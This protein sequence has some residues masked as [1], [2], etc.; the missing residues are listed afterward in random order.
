MNRRAPF[1][2]KEKELIFDKMS[3][4]RSKGLDLDAVANDIAE[5]LNASK[6]TIRNTYHKIKRDKKAEENSNQKQMSFAEEV[7]ERDIIE[8]QNEKAN[9]KPKTDYEP[10]MSE[11]V[12]VLVD[13]IEKLSKESAHWKEKFELSEAENDKLKNKLLKKFLE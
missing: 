1:S 8:V 2:V 3:L 7:N 4:A 10:N 13:K 6:Y 12:S 11:V 5:E 9:P